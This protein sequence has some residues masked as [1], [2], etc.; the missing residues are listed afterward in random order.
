MIVNRIIPASM[1][2]GDGIRLVIV[3]SGCTLGCKGCFS[4]EL[5]SFENGVERKPKELADEIEK[6]ILDNRMLS[7]ITLSGGNP[8]EQWEIVDFL[9][10]MKSR[11][12]S[13]NVWMWTGHTW[14]ELNDFEE[15]FNTL[16]YVDVVISGRFEQDKKVENRYFGSSNQEVWRKKEGKWITGD[17]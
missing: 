16:P 9:K 7:G 13:L 2:N 12:P 15:R 14:N 10:E 5:Q 17:N 1:V 3:F 6:K 8:T 4:P 11:F